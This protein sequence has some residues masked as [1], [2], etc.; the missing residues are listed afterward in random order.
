[1]RIDLPNQGDTLNVYPQ[2]ENRGELAVANGEIKFWAALSQTRATATTLLANSKL[3]AAGAAFQLQAGSLSGY[4]IITGQLDNSGGTV[5][6]KTALDDPA[7]LTVVGSYTQGANG[8]LDILVG[9]SGPSPW[10]R[11]SRSRATWTWRERWCSGVPQASS[12][13]P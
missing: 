12:L 5:I 9:P 11:A 10:P 8:T 7:V 1:M 3:T 2:F 13:S 4:G 6:P